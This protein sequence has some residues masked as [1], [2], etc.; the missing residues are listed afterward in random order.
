M[1]EFPG[2]TSLPSIVSQTPAEVGVS[3]W[4]VKGEGQ[5]T[6][7]LLGYC[8]ER[9]P[10]GRGDIGERCTSLTQ[11]LKNTE[12]NLPRRE[13]TV[14]RCF[15]SLVW[16]PV[17][18]ILSS[19]QNSLAQ[20]LYRCVIFQVGAR[21]YPVVY[22]HTYVYSYII[23]PHLGLR[24]PGRPPAPPAATTPAPQAPTPTPQGLSGQD[25]PA[26]TR[27]TSIITSSTTYYLYDMTLSAPFSGRVFAC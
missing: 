3:N 23:Q 13:V 26:L 9:H 6:T 10:L 17:L 16:G 15:F 12:D 22:I 5:P 27:T 18:S 7:L 8:W 2:C 14:T 19:F 25:Q 11:E 21:Q 1:I 20:S 24:V 4:T